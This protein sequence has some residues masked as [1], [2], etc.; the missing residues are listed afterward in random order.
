M[1][2]LSQDLLPILSLS[3]HLRLVA[4]RFSRVVIII[5]FCG[6]SIIRKTHNR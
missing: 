4:N 1:T 3:S 6:V 2:G 5:L